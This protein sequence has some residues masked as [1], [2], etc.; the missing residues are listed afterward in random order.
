MN[1]S[2]A[3]SDFEW[4]IKHEHQR[5]QGHFAAVTEICDKPVAGDP[6]EV[7]SSVP[8]HTG[9]T[10]PMRWPRLAGLTPDEMCHQLN[11]RQIAGLGPEIAV[12]TRLAA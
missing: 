10:S 8:K 12:D 1:F 5:V 2:L 3:A 9:A 7:Q 6:H 11:P 4:L